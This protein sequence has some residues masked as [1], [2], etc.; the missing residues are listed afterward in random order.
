MLISEKYK[1]LSPA[2]S[3]HQKER[4]RERERRKT[5]VNEQG[6]KYN[7]NYQSFS[8]YFFF[9]YFASV[10]FGLAYNTVNAILS[11]LTLSEPQSPLATVMLWE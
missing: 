1:L 6:N 8:S 2:Y 11:M 7:K 3:Y 5:E 4:E 10:V 9:W